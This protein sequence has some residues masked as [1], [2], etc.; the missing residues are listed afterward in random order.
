MPLRT[1][2]TSVLS[3]LRSVARTATGAADVKQPHWLFPHHSSVSTGCGL[4]L[5]DPVQ[6]YLE[7]SQMVLPLINMHLSLKMLPAFPGYSVGGEI[8]EDPTQKKKNQYPS[9]KDHY[10]KACWCQKQQGGSFCTIYSKLGTSML[11][12]NDPSIKTAGTQVLVL[13]C[14]LRG[15]H[16]ICPGQ[17]THRAHEDTC[18]IGLQI[19]TLPEPLTFRAQ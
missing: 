19:H 15:D 3:Q 7:T 17:D 9:P 13:L 6:H 16:N 10:S 18:S 12:V 14:S 2:S 11:Q 5:L 1:Y 8:Q 4:L